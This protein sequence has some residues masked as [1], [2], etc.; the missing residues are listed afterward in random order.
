MENSRPRVDYDQIAASYDQRFTG[1]QRSQTEVELHSLAREVSADCIL[2]VGCGTGRWLA[3]F[4]GVCIQLYGLDISRGMLEKAH[5]RS[6]CLHLIH[7]HAEQ[8]PLAS[9]TF[10]L[11]YCVNALHHFLR[12]REFV[13]EAYR[14]L[15]PGGVLAVVGMDPHGHYDD[16]YIYHYFEGAYQTDIERFPAWEILSE[17]MAAAGLV[18]IERR[19]VN[20]IVDSKIGWAVLK[21]PFLK[22]ESTSQLI[23]LS[24]ET[25]AEGIARIVKALTEADKRGESLIFPANIDIGMLVGRLN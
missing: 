4:E 17:W 13:H 16:W 7:A 11:I 12:P 10:D 1:E 2:E 6:A 24:D 15:C 5:Q 9:Q 18:Q 8:V 19:P 3:S 21:D 22:K 14:L 23:L 25:Y 20:H